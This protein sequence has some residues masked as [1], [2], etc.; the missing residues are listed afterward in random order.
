MLPT[1]DTNN[2]TKFDYKL[3]YSL[4]LQIPL[5]KIKISTYL[6]NIAIRLHVLYALNRHVKLCTNWILF[7]ILFI[8]LIFIQNFILQKLAI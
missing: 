8:N 6:K 5:K 4:R 7:S 2:W 3:D 1:L